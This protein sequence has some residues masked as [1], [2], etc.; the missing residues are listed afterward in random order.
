MDEVVLFRN[1]SDHCRIMI[2]N[3][4]DAV[5]EEDILALCEPLGLI[6]ELAIREYRKLSALTK[7]WN[8]FAFIRF[9]LEADAQAAAERLNLSTWRGQQILCKVASQRNKKY[10]SNRLKQ[11]KPSHMGLPLE[12]CVSLSNYL[13][14]FNNWNSEI[15]ELIPFDQ[16]KHGGYENSTDGELAYFAEKAKTGKHKTPVP[17]YSPKRPSYT[18]AVRIT[19]NG[20]V[21]MTA[22]GVGHCWDYERDKIGDGSMHENAKKRAVSNAYRTAF[23]SLAVIRL[24]NGKMD[25]RDLTAPPEA[26]VPAPAFCN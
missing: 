7:G 16:Q 9:F 22:N 1:P 19:V 10:M 17:T 2:M 18:C 4:H 21:Q 15:L 3:I 20:I 23:N 14:G 8:Y 6:H 11:P 26:S 5:S 13:F 24:R 12:K 25:I